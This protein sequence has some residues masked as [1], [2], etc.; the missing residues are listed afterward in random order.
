MLFIQESL[1][2]GAGKGLFTDT[3]IKKGKIIIEYTG[4]KLTWAQCEK[5]NNEQEGLNG[6]FFF[7]SKNNCID[8]Q[9][10]LDS[11]GRYAND[12]QGYKKVEGLKNNAEYQIIKRKPYIIAKKNIK[13]G[14]EIFVSYGKEY[15]DVMK[16]Y[17]DKQYNQPTRTVSSKT[18][19]FTAELI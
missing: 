8:A 16:E 13:A 14:E 15:W 9:H 10:T 7:V 4:E 1:I 5:R 2:P 19:E 17:F 12:A 3:L 11:L 6:Y 18:Q